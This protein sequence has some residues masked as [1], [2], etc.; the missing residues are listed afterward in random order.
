MPYKEEVF[1][2]SCVVSERQTNAK[3]VYLTTVDEIKTLT[4]TLPHC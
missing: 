1:N 3:K 4:K 2:V